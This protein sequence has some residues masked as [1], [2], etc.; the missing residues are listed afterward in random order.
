MIC[1]YFIVMAIVMVIVPYFLYTVLTDSSLT[2]RRKKT[3]VGLAVLF[4]LLLFDASFFGM[5][6]TLML[7]ISLA[8]LGIELLTMIEEVIGQAI[9]GDSR[10]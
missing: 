5:G 9:W 4:V 6:L 1:G 7:I 10:S 2:R 8:Q 3:T